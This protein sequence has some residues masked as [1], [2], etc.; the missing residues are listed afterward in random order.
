MSHCVQGST[1]QVPAIL[2]QP[3]ARIGVIH[4]NKSAV[5]ESMVDAQTAEG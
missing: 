2:L 4:Y 5:R 3:S 1:I